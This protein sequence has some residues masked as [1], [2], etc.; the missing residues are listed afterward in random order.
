MNKWLDFGGDPDHRLDTGI[1]SGFVTVGRYGKWYKPTALCDAAV[2]RRI[3]YNVITPPAHD[4]QPR[5]TW[6]GGGM[7]CPSASSS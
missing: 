3:N 7:H 4:R 2:R 6:L 5:Q 1:F